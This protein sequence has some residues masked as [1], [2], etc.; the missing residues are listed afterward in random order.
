MAYFHTNVLDNQIKQMPTVDTA[1]G[2]VATFDTDLTENLV[3]CVCDIQYSQ[4]SGTP[5]PS[6]PIPITVYNSLNLSHSGADTSNPT[7]INIPFGQTVAKG[8]LDVLSG[9]LA[10]EWSG[11]DLYTLTDWSYIA[12]YNCFSATVPNIKQALIGPE[13]LTGILSSN[14]KISDTYQLANMPNE[15]CLRYTNKVYIKDTRYTDATSF[16][17][18]LQN[19]NAQ[20]IYERDNITNVQVSSN[21]I[22]ALLNENNIWCDTNGNTKVKFLL[23]IGKAVA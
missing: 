5:T 11:I 18:A 6:D 16:K 15:S 9:V 10:V 19:E 8:T 23:S 13:R 1:S 14:Y 12:N 3:S 22:T 7:I 17:T 20:L 4:A 2:R 21:Q